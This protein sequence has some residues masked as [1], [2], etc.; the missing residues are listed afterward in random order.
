MSSPVRAFR[1]FASVL[2]LSAVA[3]TPAAATTF[4]VS[5]TNDTGAGSLRTA[6]G[7]ANNT[8]GTHTI[9]ASGVT[10]TISLQSALPTLTN[11]TL[12]INGPA[13]GIGTLTVTRGVGT[14]FRIFSIANSGGAANVTINRLTMTNG[15]TGAVS[16]GDDGGCIQ[17]NG[18][19]TLSVNYSVVS[20][21]TT[22]VDGG[23]IAI[24]GSAGGTLNVDHTTLSGNTANRGG[25]LSSI[26]QTVTGTV[27]VT[28]STISGNTATSNAAGANLTFAAGTFRNTTISGNTANTSNGGGLMGGSSSSLTAINCTITGNNAPAG[29]AG[30]IRGN[31]SAP[32]TLT[33]TIVAGNTAGG[34]ADDVNWT[35]GTGTFT[36]NY[37][38]VGVA[39][40]G[41]FDTTTQSSIGSSASPVAVNLGPLAWNGGLTRTHA[42]LATAANAIDLGSNAGLSQDQ[43]D[44]TR[45]VDG[46][47]ANASGGDGSDIGA[48]ER[49][50]FVWTGASGT[51]FA[52]AGNWADGVAPLIGDDVF[53]LDGPVTNEPTVT[54]SKTVH[55]LTVGVGH[56]LTV[57]SGATLTMTNS[58]TVNGTLVV[59]GVI[60]F[61][62]VY[63]G[64]GKVVYSGSTPQTISNS[65]NP[66]AVLEIN[67]AAGVKLAG[68]MSVTN[69]L[70]LL[71]DLDTN[72]NFLTLFGLPCSSITG[73]GDVV[74]ETRRSSGIALGTAYCMGNPQNRITFTGGSAPTSV[75]VTLTKSAPGS[76]TNAVNRTYAVSA[77]G[78]AGYTGTLRLHYLDAEL[79][80]NTEGSLQLWRQS[81]TFAAQGQ[82]A[83]DS[84]NDYV[85]LSGISTANVTGTWAIASTGPVAT[86][87]ATVTGHSPAPSNI[88]Q[89]VSLTA[90]VTGTG[91]TPTG[92]VQ[93]QV[94]AA[95]VGTAQTLV[96]GNAGITYAFPVAGTHDVTAVYSGDGT[97]SGTTSAIVTHQVNGT[98]ATAGQLV[99]SEFRFAGTAGPT[100]EY[101]EIHNPTA[102]AHT[103]ATNDGSAGYALR[104]SDN[105]TRFVIPNG[106]VI[107]ARGF[108]LA[109]NTVAY[110]IAGYPAGAGGASLDTGGTW[111]A[112][113]A[114]DTGIALFNSAAT[115]TD[116]GTRLDAVG[117]GAVAALYREG[118]AGIPTLGATTQQYAWMR[119]LATGAPL[120]T[121]VNASDFVL[122]STTGTAIGA[123]SPVLGGPNPENTTGPRLTTSGILPELLDPS[124]SDALAPNRVRTPGAVPNG[125]LG[126]MEFRR[127]FTNQTG[128]GVTRLRFRVIDITTTNSPAVYAP[129]AVLK[130]LSATDQSNV[131]TVAH[132][133]IAT[134]KG[135]T[136]EAVPTQTAGGLG[137]SVTVN[138]GGTLANNG[139]VDVDF[140]LGVESKGNFNY[141]VAWELLP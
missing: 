47:A 53:I 72:G 111:T 112:D 65:L 123:Q 8:G 139:F 1:R 107:P 86:A 110:S 136:L 52:T 88:G 95:N 4:T 121:N 74:G 141:F 132:G 134:V 93:F 27:L 84:T 101:V 54:A 63:S 57:A 114:N 127:R 23:G 138:L 135:A 92:T 12:T 67:N 24:N 85:E 115:F 7:S 42:L 46:P 125:A 83:L 116:P 56:T 120:D 91:A 75:S 77:T 100:D 20:G 13:I 45:P 140:L 61:P 113:I 43:R 5:N 32:I 3:A 51:T 33:N 50:T 87:T 109:G 64:S 31:S 89:N 25:G 26:I 78:G 18:G 35:N 128:A 106:T 60:S 118:A 15:S 30:G 17:V 70:N 79:N 137:S 21:C 59:Q 76:F 66:V 94:D 14:P 98:P 68:A 96:G 71:T 34:I 73:P 131:S 62:G 124:T 44:V 97:Y 9:D 129:Q 102:T 16:P 36:A 108:Y 2:L 117:T 38:L 58:L 48:Y 133:V 22:G 40:A 90:S 49:G 126:T 41:A 81:G 104:A 105:V 29:I 19:A 122:I 82:T 130:V 99:I 55:N 6:I 103:V 10:G 11:V 80:G 69:G 28:N 37:A 39:T 119:K